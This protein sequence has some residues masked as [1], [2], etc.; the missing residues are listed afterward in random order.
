MF[1]IDRTEHGAWVLSGRLDADNADRLREALAEISESCDLDFS[2]LDYISSAGIGILVATQRRLADHG[3]G[4]RLT[5]LTDHIKEVFQL[6]GLHSI[7]TI[8]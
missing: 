8:E 7:F 5:G 3:H 2:A 4:L 1:A 6:A